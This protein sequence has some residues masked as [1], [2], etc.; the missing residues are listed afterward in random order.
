MNPV[1][2][3]NFGTR[4]SY[5]PHV[6]AVATRGREGSSRG[7]WKLSDADVRWSGKCVGW[8]DEKEDLFVES[9][10]RLAGS[11]PTGPVA[12]ADYGGLSEGVI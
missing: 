6:R 8:L 4:H 12:K 2:P 1:N 9:D 10:T 3:V 11:R 5:R 7:F